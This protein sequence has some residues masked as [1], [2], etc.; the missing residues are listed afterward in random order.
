[1]AATLM[2]DLK[3]SDVLQ[4]RGL[5]LWDARFLYA[6]QNN[7]VYLCCLLLPGH[8]LHCGNKAS[9]ETPQFLSGTHTL[10]VWKAV[11]LLHIFSSEIMFSVTSEDTV[12]SFYSLPFLFTLTLLKGD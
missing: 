9:T 4:Q 12:T 2:V 3:F 1:M 11:L 7:F 10:S 8:L 6:D 5:L